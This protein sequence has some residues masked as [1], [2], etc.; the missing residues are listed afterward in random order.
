MCRA[1]DTC[2]QPTLRA[3]VHKLHDRLVHHD[4]LEQP[5]VDV[6]VRDSPSARMAGPAASAMSEGEQELDDGDRADGENWVDAATER[7]L[8][9]LHVN[10]PLLIEDE[11]TSRHQPITKG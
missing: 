6:E 3:Q 9:N 1:L 10:S 11:P 7:A 8:E 2:M 4:T 5:V